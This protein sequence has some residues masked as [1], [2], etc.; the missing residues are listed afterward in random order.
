M[1][2]VDDRSFKEV[3]DN[4]RDLINW[5]K[6]LNEEEEPG[7]TKKIEDDAAEELI[8]K[9]HAIANKLGLGTLV[10]GKKKKK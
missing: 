5:I 2:E 10:A 7:A 1:V 6:V 9:I 3:E 4:L 8:E